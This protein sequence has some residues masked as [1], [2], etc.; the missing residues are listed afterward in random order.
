[1]KN[2][3]DQEKYKEVLNDYNKKYEKL[4]EDAKSAEEREA[5][6]HFHEILKPCCHNEDRG[7]DGWCKTCGSPGF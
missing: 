3:I 5:I 2:K 1:M 7:W 4:I 6:R